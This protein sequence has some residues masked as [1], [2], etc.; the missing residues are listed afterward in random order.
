[1]VVS[2]FVWRL[3]GYASRGYGVVDLLEGWFWSVH[4]LGDLASGSSLFV[5][6][7]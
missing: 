3:M 2:Q 4:E 1:M 5:L 6:V 7:P